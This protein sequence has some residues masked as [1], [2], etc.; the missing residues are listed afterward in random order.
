MRAPEG[1]QVQEKSTKEEEVSQVTKAETKTSESKAIKQK[2]VV[3]FGARKSILQKGKSTEVKSK[4]FDMLKELHQLKVKMLES[5]DITPIPIM[6]QQLATEGVPY[7]GIPY[8]I[9]QTSSL[10]TK[11]QSDVK[12]R[13]ILSA[14]NTIANTS[15]SLMEDVKPCGHK[16]ELESLKDEIQKHITDKEKLT[17]QV[18]DQKQQLERE[19]RLVKHTKKGFN[20]YKDQCVYL[21]NKNEQLE[22]TIRRLR[23][24]KVGLEAL[25][26]ELSGAI[27]KHYVSQSLASVLKSDESDDAIHFSLNELQE[28][29]E[30]LITKIQNCSKEHNHPLFREFVLKYLEEKYKDAPKAE[31]EDDKEEDDEEEDEDKEDDKDDK[32]DDDDEDDDDDQGG[33]ARKD[34]EKKDDDEDEEEEHDEPPQS[35]EVKIKRF[36]DKSSL[37]GKKHSTAK[38]SSQNFSFSEVLHEGENAMYWKAVALKQMFGKW[39][40]KTQLARQSAYMQKTFIKKFGKTA[41]NSEEYPPKLEGVVQLV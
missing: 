28:V 1:F 5:Q 19:Q 18:T 9:P 30:G 4:K 32:G 27:V 21:Q 17:A 10:H 13:T 16:S 6:L 26:K 11:T 22:K 34:D 33:P 36:N 35:K 37:K 38:H 14:I 24:K 23:R 39:Q 2:E 29:E 25:G 31:E 15:V 7:E 12:V 40:L 3:V 41:K 20:K 8:V